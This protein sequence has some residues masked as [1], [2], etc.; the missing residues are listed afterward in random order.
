MFFAIPI[1]VGFSKVLWFGS[2]NNRS[3]MI[4]ELLGRSLEDLFSYC[5]RRFSLKTV[6]VL[7]YE[8]VCRIETIH[9]KGFIHRDIKPENFL[10]GRGR[11]RHTVYV[12]DFG[13]AKYYRSASGTHIPLSEGYSLTG[14]ARYASVNAHDGLGMQSSNVISRCTILTCSGS[15]SSHGGTTCTPSATC[16]CT[17]FA[18]RFLGRALS[19][20]LAKT[21]TSSYSTRSAPRPRRNSAVKTLVFQVT[22]RLS[23]LKVYLRVYYN[24][25]LLADEFR[26][27]FAHL[28]VLQFEDRPDY[29]Y[30]KGLFRD[31]FARRRFTHDSVLFDWEV[32][33]YQRQQQQQQQMK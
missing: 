30:L 1:T 2:N 18:V 29:A 25:C 26:A 24:H 33:A 15:Q 14:T 32:L 7:A 12:I 19:A 31:L 22:M 9:S 5:G 20:L 11:S 28:D 4:M 8:L 6:L 27:Y 21:N 16:C 3:V 17:F 10:M 13:L 23:V